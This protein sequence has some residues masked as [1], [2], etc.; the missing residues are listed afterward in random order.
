MITMIPMKLT[1]IRAITVAAIAATL[2]GC[3]E[4]KEKQ[5]EERVPVTVAQ[6]EQRDVPVEVRVIGSVQPISSVAVRALVAGQLQ[7][8][9]FRE[10]DDVRKGQRLFTIDERPYQSA[11]AQAEGNLARDVA[12]AK[13]ADAEAKRYAE[14][15]KKDYVTREEYD[16]FLSGAEAAQ[17]VVAADRA[18]V[19][20]ARLQLAYCEIFSPLDGRTGSL[21]VQAGNLVKANDTTPLVAIN[22]ITPVYVTFSVPESQL[23]DVRARGFGNVPVSASPQ[24]GGVAQNGKLTFMDNAVDPQTGTITLKATFTNEGRVLWP[25]EFVNVAMTLSNRRNATVVPVQAVQ[26][27]QKGQYVYVVT[28]GNGIQMHPV[29]VIQQVDNQAVIGQGVNPGDTVVTD[30]QIRL[31][32]KSKVEVKKSL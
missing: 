19:E 27:G 28:E 11:L 2:L 25:G 29:T 5:V 24:Q 9:W 13:N 20:S 8:V 23:G 10:G 7:R 21:Q 4:K 31:T 6:A 12:Q 15:V 14:L 32:P 26:N 1:G 16:K 22:Q 17:A 30:G 3:S 18:T